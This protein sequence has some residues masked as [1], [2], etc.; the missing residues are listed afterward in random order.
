VADKAIV[1]GTEWIEISVSLGA[2]SSEDVPA[3]DAA[4]LV[5][6]ADR[7]LYE[8]KAARRNCVRRA[9]PNLGS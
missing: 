3:A 1:A 7:A 8:A 9:L 5:R 4:A 2:A 6:A